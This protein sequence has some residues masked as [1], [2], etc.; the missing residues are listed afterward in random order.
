MRSVV[1]LCAVALGGCASI[2][3][4]TSQEI[5]INT[6]PAG[7]SCVLMREGQPIGSVNP[8]PGTVLI[9][10]TKYDLTIVCDRS[11]F[12]QATHWLLA[13]SATILLF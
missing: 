5:T 8:T 3:E 2:V 6:N 4:G 11:G 1:A 7:A 12:D 13:A 10:K 9:K